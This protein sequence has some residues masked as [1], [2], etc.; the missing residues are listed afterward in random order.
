MT[1]MRLAQTILTI[2]THAAITSAESVKV[3]KIVSAS[4]RASEWVGGFG[5]E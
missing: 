3:E 5:R 2:H 4:E 1:P